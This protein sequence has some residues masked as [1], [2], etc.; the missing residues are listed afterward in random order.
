MFPFF[1]RLA[2]SKDEL[3]T[4]ALDEQ[5]NYLTARELVTGDNPLLA[6]CDTLLTTA[7]QRK[8]CKKQGIAEVL[9]E[10]TRL[11]VLE[12]QHQYQHE[13]WNCSMAAKHRSNTLNKGRHLF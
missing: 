6:L 4:V 5:D 2:S 8:M 3:I 13:R 12:C 7:I 10:A 1:F 9:V 11:S